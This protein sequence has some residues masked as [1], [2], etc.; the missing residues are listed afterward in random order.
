MDLH[1]LSLLTAPLSAKSIIENSYIDVTVREGV[2]PSGAF[3]IALP[4]GW[5]MDQDDPGVV[6]GESDPVI[7]L[8]R[9]TPELPDALGAIERPQ[10]VVW[11]A[12]LPR[13]IHGADWLHSWIQT[14]GFTKIQARELPS[15]FGTMGDALVYRNKDDKLML[16]RLLTIKDGDLLFLIDGRVEV[17]TTSA[18]KLEAMQEIMLMA[19]LRFRLL[20]PSGQSF[21]EPFEPQT[22]E[23]A[24]GKVSLLLPA[25]WSA[26]I[27]TDAPSEGGAHILQNQ[28]AD[29]V[30]G[31]LLITLGGHRDSAE[32]M[33]A[34]TRAK[35]VGQGYE[36]AESGVV[37][38][39]RKDESTVK[40]VLR[41]EGRLDGQPIAILTARVTFDQL[42][43][44]IVLISPTDS[45]LFEAWAINRRAFDIALG[46]LQRI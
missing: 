10:I 46:S 21:A 7:P 34:I 35:L 29:T 27:A 11:A 22:V 39:D 33:E 2:F 18:G 19:L 6:P 8:A 38:I 45:V 30:A 26:Q 36:L 1:S 14:Q 43:V 42:P 15:K 37:L 44:S 31:T 13:E 28:Q 5:R 41:Y 25:S 9:F 40:Q 17:T 3:S 20:E 23:G 16:H 32:Q 4:K 24:K 12:V